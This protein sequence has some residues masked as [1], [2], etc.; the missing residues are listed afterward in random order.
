[1]TLAL[2]SEI[3]E[4]FLDEAKHWLAIMHNAPISR[5]ALHKHLWDCG[6][7]HKHLQKSAQESDEDARAQWINQI[8]NYVASQC[9]AIYELSK[10][11]CTM[12]CSCGCYDFYRN[13]QFI[14]LTPH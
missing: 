7:I 13:T 12:M 5:M 10:D 8:K 6:L 11:E 2:F 1:M 4:L 3:L 9:I 14:P